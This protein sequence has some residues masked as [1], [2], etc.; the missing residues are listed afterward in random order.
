MRTRIQN[1]EIRKQKPEEKN[2]SA[3]ILVTFKNNGAV[4]RAEGL[5]SAP[6]KH[7]SNIPVMQ[8]TGAVK[9]LWKT[10]VSRQGRGL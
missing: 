7:G 10:R 1:T 5:A 9:C 2:I 4:N 3:K 8:S 6:A